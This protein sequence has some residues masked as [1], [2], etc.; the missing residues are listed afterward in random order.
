MQAH[1]SI[2][3]CR[4]KKALFAVNWR[5]IQLLCTSTLYPLIIFRPWF[6]S[7]KFKFDCLNVYMKMYDTILYFKL[8][9]LSITKILIL[10]MFWRKSLSIQSIFGHNLSTNLCSTWKSCSSCHNWRCISVKVSSKI[11]SLILESD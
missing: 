9:Q 3:F 7:P 8:Y 2:D 6:Q 10:Q 4:Q 5:M 11:D 1:P